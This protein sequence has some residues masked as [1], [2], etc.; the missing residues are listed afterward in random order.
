MNGL[1]RI[2]VSGFRRFESVQDLELRPLTVV[3]GQNG[4]GKSSFIEL[5]ML[6]SKSARGELRAAV[7]ASGGL[8]SILTRGRAQELSVE[9]GARIDGVSLRYLLA[10]ERE[11]LDY[12]IGKEQFGSQQTPPETLLLATD[13]MHVEFAHV[14][15]VGSRS[16]KKDRS[17]TALSFFAHN[18][19]TADVFVDMLRAWGHYAGIDFDVGVRGT[20]R[21]PQL[22]RPVELPGPRG[23]DLVSCLFYLREAK[24]D[25][26]EMVHDALAAAFPTFERLDFLPVA[27]GMLAITWKDRDFSQPIY[28]HELSD[29]TL[30]FLWLVTLLASPGLSAITLIDEPGISLHPSML[31]MLSDLLREAAARTQLIVATHSESLVRFLRPD[32]VLALDVEDGHAVAHWGDTFDLEPWLKDYTLDQIWRMNRM[33]ANP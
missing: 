10:L 15:G 20:V 4:V 31:M 5:L 28:A 23:E 33:G 13:P 25:R 21:S 27:A 32:E 3:I 19:K 30:R 6:L 26:Y 17:E 24:R 16:R 29:G 22:L 18:V 8:S 1:T 7:T 11:G 12:I 9:V 14:D 2:S